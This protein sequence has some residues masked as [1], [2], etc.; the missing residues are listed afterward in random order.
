MFRAVS[1]HVGRYIYVNLSLLYSLS[2]NPLLETKKLYI[3]IRGKEIKKNISTKNKV[4][5]SK[6]SADPPLAT[7][8]RGVII[9]HIEVKIEYM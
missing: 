1:L 4:F 2:V 7:K 8:I 6:P 5:N 9:V 3:I